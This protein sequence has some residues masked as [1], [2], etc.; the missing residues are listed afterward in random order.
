MRLKP[1]KSTIALLSGTLVLV[2]FVT[3]G[4]VWYQ[5]DSLGKTLV[6]L[7]QKKTEMHDGQRIARRREEAHAALEQDRQQL[8]FLENGVSDA[9]Y[10]PTLLKQ[11]EELAHGTQNQVLGV[12]PQVETAAPTRIQQRRDPDAAAKGG[13]SDAKDKDGK[14]KTEAKPEPYTRLCIQVSLE[15]CYKSTQDFLDHLTRFP[16]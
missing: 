16:K 2:V 10:V 4:I 8:A 1:T 13:S 6:S 12:R 7:E 15:G 14:D 11:L 9:A 3:G 5:Q